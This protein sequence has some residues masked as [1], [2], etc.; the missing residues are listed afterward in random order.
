MRGQYEDQQVA[1]AIHFGGCRLDGGPDRF[2]GHIAT[3][4]GVGTGYDVASL[5]S[6]GED[7]GGAFG[8]ALEYALG[9]DEPECQNRDVR[10]SNRVR[11]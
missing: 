9:T 4:F 2:D 8:F 5:R 1:V 11:R 3:G 6:L 7:G 10:V